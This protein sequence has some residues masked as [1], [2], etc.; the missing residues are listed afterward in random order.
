MP[1]IGK[2]LRGLHAAVDDERRDTMLMKLDLEGQD[3]DK[4]GYSEENDAT[5]SNAL[6]VELDA[7]DMG[8]SALKEKLVRTY[9]GVM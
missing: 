1:S 7:V 3:N 9:D 5:Q 2:C 8:V 6:E 4:S